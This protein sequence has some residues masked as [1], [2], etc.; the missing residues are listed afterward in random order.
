MGTNVSSRIAFSKQ[1]K[2]K[3]KRPNEINYL[4][5]EHWTWFALSSFNKKWLVALSLSAL[6]SPVSPSSSLTSNDVINWA[7]I[8]SNSLTSLAQEGLHY[9]DIQEKYNR[10]QYQHEI[11]NGTAKLRL[12]RQKLGTSALWCPLHSLFRF[13]C[14]LIIRD[15]CAA[16]FGY[17]LLTMI[18]MIQTFKIIKCLLNDFGLL[19]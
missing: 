3:L 13:G 1:K 17:T 12:V 5:F 8:M 16:F 10:A 7:Q 18:C 4:K 19:H 9:E 6:L 2:L 11:T 14:L 15:E